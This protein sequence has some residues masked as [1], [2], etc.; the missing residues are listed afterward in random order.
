MTRRR[1]GDS[2]LAKTVRWYLANRSWWQSIQQSGYEARRLGL[3]VPS[4]QTI[5]RLD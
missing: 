5:A 1:D 2:G 3:A 4:S